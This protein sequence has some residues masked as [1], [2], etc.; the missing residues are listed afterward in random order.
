MCNN[1]LFVLLCGLM[2]T[3]P[4]F[5]CQPS[6]IDY[7]L[8]AHACC[9]WNAIKCQNCCLCFIH[10]KLYSVCKCSGASTEF[11]FHLW[12]IVCSELSLAW[13]QNRFRLVQYLLCRQNRMNSF[14]AEPMPGDIALWMMEIRPHDNVETANTLKSIDS[15]AV[16]TA[17]QIDDVYLRCPLAP[18]INLLVSY[19]CQAKTKTSQLQQKKETICVFSAR[20]RLL[21]FHA[22]WTRS[23][24]PIWRSRGRAVA[25]TLFR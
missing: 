5:R 25:F 15:S 19:F 12:K 22:A 2:G 24:W 16:S 6:A 8:H 11:H 9:T 18:A 1:D 4:H 10:L 3:F 7:L 17:Q 21:H 23:R 13:N 14:D 20:W